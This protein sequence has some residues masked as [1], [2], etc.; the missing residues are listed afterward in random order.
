MRLG[1]TQPQRQENV[2]PLW[3]PQFSP[4]MMQC[5][6]AKNAHP[7][8][9]FVYDSLPGGIQKKLLRQSGDCP[10]RW[11]YKSGMAL[12]FGKFITIIHS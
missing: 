8:P 10:G 1:V 12:V 5:T 2:T 3:C 11:G 6:V 7:H 4:P 9:T